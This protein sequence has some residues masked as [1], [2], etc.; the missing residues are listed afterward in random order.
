[1][2]GSRPGRGTR[3][4]G[5]L[6]GD[7]I[8]DEQV[9]REPLWIAFFD[10]KKVYDLVPWWLMHGVRAAGRTQSDHR[11]VPKLLCAPAT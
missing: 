5:Q 11:G 4:L 8:A 6:L 9:R 2:F 3:Q 1:M 7:L 10:L